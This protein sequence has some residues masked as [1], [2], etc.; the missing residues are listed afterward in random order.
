M[1]HPTPHVVITVATMPAV[2]SC[3]SLPRSCCC[4]W[5]VTSAASSHSFTAVP[6]LCAVLL[7][8]RAVPNALLMS[9]WPSCSSPWWQLLSTCTCLRLTATPPHVCLQLC[10]SCDAAAACSTSCLRISQHCRGCLT[11]LLLS[12]LRSLWLQLRQDGESK[13]CCCCCSYGAWAVGYT[14]WQPRGPALHTRTMLAHHPVL[15]CPTNLPIPEW[16]G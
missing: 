7:C 10:R 6:L 13:L 3:C 14:R 5:A 11:L 12:P 8:C 1:E 16:C 4:W 2:R 15:R 9:N